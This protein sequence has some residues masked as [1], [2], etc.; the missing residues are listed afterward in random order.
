MDIKQ[1]E[2][3]LENVRNRRLTLVIQYQQSKNIKLSAELHKNQ[4]RLDRQIELLSKDIARIDT[5][6]DKC[7]DRIKLIT[8][9]KNE[10]SFV[11]SMME[12]IDE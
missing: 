2:K 6:Y 8:A 5:L 11:T 7:Q 10:N 9:L 1:I 4:S 12:E 3:H